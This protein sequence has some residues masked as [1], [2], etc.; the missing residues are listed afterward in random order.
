[1]ERYS[2]AGDEVWN[3]I[4]AADDILDE[5]DLGAEAQIKEIAAATVP[6]EYVA[7][8][9]DLVESDMA[10][11]VCNR[12]TKPVALLRIHSSHHSLARCMAMG[13]KDTHT[14][15]IT[16]Y[17]PS[18]ISILKNDPAFTALVADYRAEAKAIFADLGERMAD[19]SLDAIE[20][21]HER[22]QAKPEDFSIPMLL[23]VVKA[24]ADRTGHGPGQEITMKVAKD[25]I[26]RPPRESF[27]EWEARRA[28]ELNLS[29]EPRP[30]IKKLN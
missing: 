11:L 4:M 6:S 15:L 18:R 10:A 17:S 2:Q 29:A 26:D 12:G 8:T 14:S 23:D 30:D 22:L 25:F 28:K 20:L 19:I 5:L 13:L 16:G 3:S 24:F 1:M 9:R 21:L 7:Y 27:E